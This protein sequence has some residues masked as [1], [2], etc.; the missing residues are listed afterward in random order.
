MSA[1]ACEPSCS[2]GDKPD[3]RALFEAVPGLYLVLDVNL[4]IVAVSDAYLR[5]T[6]TRREAIL[7]RGIF[8][9]FPDNPDDPKADGVR[10]LQASLHRVVQSGMADAMAVQKYDVRKPEAEGGGF[11]ERYWSPVNSPVLQADGSLAYIIHRVEDVTEFVQLKQQ[12]S[13]HDRY[14]DALR[15]RASQMEAEV[16]ARGREV[17]EANIRLK[18]ANQELARLYQKTREL[19]NLKTQFFANVSHELRTPL[20]LILGPISKCLADCALSDERRRDLHMVER[21]ARLLHHHVDDLLDIAKLEAGRMLVQYAQ[22]DLAR[23][24]RFL[25]A[26]FESLAEEKRISYRIQAPEALPAQVDADKCQRIILNLLS[27]ALKFTPEGGAIVVALQA[28]NDH[29]VIVVQDNGPGVPAALHDVV[30][31]RFRQ[32]DGGNKRLHG[33]TGLGLA[34]VKEFAEL[35]GGSAGVAD[36]PGGGAVFTVTLPLTAPAD[37]SVVSAPPVPDVFSPQLP[38]QPRSAP[39]IT[40]K[41]DAPLI[42]V[43]ED[44][45]DMNA[46]VS[47]VLAEHYRVATACDG[48]E[49]MEQALALHPD[50]IITDVMMPGISGDQMALTLRCHPEM[51]DVPIVMLTA[52]ADDGLRADMLRNAV[53]DYLHKPFSAYELLARVDGLVTEWRRKTLALRESETRFRA[54]FEQAAV[55]IAH[56]APDGRWLR[57]NHKLCD[58]V[59]YSPEEMLRQSFQ[60]ITH[61]EDL[62]GDLSQM[63]RLLTGE[64]DTYTLDKRYIRKGG[65]PIWINLT[66]SLVRDTDGAPAYFISVIEDIQRRK[67]SE[68]EVRRLNAELERRVDERTKALQVVNQELESFAYAVSHDLRAPLRAMIGFGEALSEECGDAVQGDARLYVDEILAASRNMGEL[69]DGLLLLSRCG[70]GELRRDL[71]DLSELAKQILGE[72]ATAN[73]DRRVECQVEPALSAWGD[74]RLIEVVMR[75]LLANSWKYTA[76]TAAP[77]IRFFAEDN[78]SERYYCVADNG[79][80]FDTRHAGKLFKPFSRLHRQDEFPGIGIGL[81][82]VQRVVQRHGG[83]IQA[84]G[85]PNKG[86]TFQFSLPRESKDQECEVTQ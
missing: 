50:L 55:G 62:D 75:N 42:L 20:A 59:G 78:G 46:F 22:I 81:A 25:A 11:E 30:F 52:K 44:N 86:A 63:Q 7:G 12:E 57:V 8:D 40:A 77:T 68:T 18:Q 70:R 84:E 29:A 48:Q 34:I 51:D 49:G 23:L 24:L 64:I 10:H 17:A 2:G 67:D 1:N 56:V 61:P 4:R 73:P 3:F 45:P 43:V 36:A 66:V 79:A 41:A 15:E 80:G 14:A 82:T 69:I 37:V 65:Q 60:E 38:A 33:G 5:A 6:M 32:L 58:I 76:K 19:D 54:T 74:R 85:T 83:S 9:V 71:V 13:E 39:V 35:H 16:Y 53:Q 27:N 47:E 21:N 72:L 28:A 26:H 31:E